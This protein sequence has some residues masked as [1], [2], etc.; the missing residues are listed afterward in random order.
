M[1]NLPTDGAFICYSVAGF[2]FEELHID[3]QQKMNME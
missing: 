1:L 3:R 2:F